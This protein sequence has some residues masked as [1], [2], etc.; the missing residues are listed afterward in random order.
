MGFVVSPFQEDEAADQWS[1][2]AVACYALLLLTCALLLTPSHRCE[3]LGTAALL[4][5]CGV[6]VVVLERGEVAQTFRSW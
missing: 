2:G 3:G 5:Q 6:D 1:H 4:E